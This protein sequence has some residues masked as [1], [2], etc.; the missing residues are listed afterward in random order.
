M[1]IIITWICHFD[2][3]GYTYANVLN[4]EECIFTILYY[5]LKCSSY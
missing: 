3:L 1:G 4:N 2:N 5:L